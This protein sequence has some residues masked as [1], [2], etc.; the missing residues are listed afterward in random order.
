MLSTKCQ[1]PQML[2]HGQKRFLL[3]LLVFLSEVINLLKLKLH[4]KLFLQTS[5]YVLLFIEKSCLPTIGCFITKETDQTTLTSSDLLCEQSE[6]VGTIKS[7]AICS[8]QQGIKTDGNVRSLALTFLAVFC[9][10]QKPWQLFLPLFVK[11]KGIFR[12]LGL[13]FAHCPVY[14]WQWDMVAYACVHG[15]THIHTHKIHSLVQY[16]MPNPHRH[17]IFICAHLPG[18][19]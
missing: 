11:Y 13:C 1:W 5:T 3:A 7:S 18:P 19:D 2:V 9:Q 14:V 10:L 4:Q 8:N 6:R 12:F 16:L 17:L 15:P